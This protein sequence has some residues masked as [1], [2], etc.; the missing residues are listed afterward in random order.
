MRKYKPPHVK[1]G[2]LCKI[3]MRSESLYKNENKFT[4]K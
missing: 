4:K 2:K 3:R 1:F